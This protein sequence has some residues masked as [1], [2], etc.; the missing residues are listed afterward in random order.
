ML[1]LVIRFIALPWASQS[2]SLFIVFEDALGLALG[3]HAHE[4][5]V[6]SVNTSVLK[7]LT[8]KNQQCF[9]SYANSYFR[10][11]K[12][13]ENMS[14]VSIWSFRRLLFSF[15]FFIWMVHFHTFFNENPAKLKEGLISKYMRSSVKII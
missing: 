11:C 9:P 4:N 14:F 8:Q 1:L 10:S 5:C 7:T 15:C 12:R 13:W 6:F 2:V 3:E